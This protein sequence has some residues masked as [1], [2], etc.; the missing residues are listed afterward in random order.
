MQATEVE[1][2]YLT[3]K[4][5]VATLTDLIDSVCVAAKKENEIESIHL[6]AAIINTILPYLG[7]YQAALDQ[8]AERLREEMETYED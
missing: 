4:V 8:Y 3:T 2:K 6:G 1:L 7:V 5:S